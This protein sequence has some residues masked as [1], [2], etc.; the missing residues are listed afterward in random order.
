MANINEAPVPDPT[1][2]SPE[3]KTAWRLCAFAIASYVFVFSVQSIGVK[4]I[5][6]ALPK[7][8]IVS[9]CVFFSIWLYCWWYRKNENPPFKPPGG[10]KLL[11]AGAFTDKTHRWNVSRVCVERDGDSLCDHVG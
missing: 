10:G 6:L 4:G 1:S 7:L 8:S 11:F 5:K 9:M 3:E 2:L